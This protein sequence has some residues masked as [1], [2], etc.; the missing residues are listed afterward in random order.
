MSS[1]NN[2]IPEHINAYILVNSLRDRA[3]LKALRDETAQMP[4]AGMQISPDQGQFMALLVKA[5]GAKLAIEVGTFTGYSALVVAGALPADGKLV[6][7]DVSEEFTSVGR[8]HWE[9]AG[10]T[11]KIDL[12]LGPAVDTLDAMI[13]AGEN[14]QYDMAFIDADKE[15]YGLYYERCLILLRVGGLILVDNVLWDGRVADEAEQDESTQAIRALTKKMHADER[16]DFSLLPVG[17]GLS[18][19]VKR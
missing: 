12:R 19:A 16:I 14:G 15:N 9:K 2:N 3:E 4:M 13:A 5:T 6:A 7:C 17:D 8:P 11:D 1:R 10:L 18:L